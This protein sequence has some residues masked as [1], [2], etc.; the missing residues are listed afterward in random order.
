[1]DLQSLN[2]S[3]IEEFRANSGKVAGNFDGMPLLLINIIGAKSGKPYTK[4]LAYIVDGDRF[5]VI[6]SYAGHEHNPPWYH[7][8]L[9]HPDIDIEVEDQVIPVTASVAGEPERTVLFDKMASAMPV[10]SDYQSKSS[11]LIPVVIFA[12]R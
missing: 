11:R 4:P 1:M 2:R 12:R 5:V 8:L 9:A 7:N 6:A 3:V 10:F